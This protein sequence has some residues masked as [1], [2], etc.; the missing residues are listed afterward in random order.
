MQNNL[1][2]PVVFLLLS[3]KGDN[4]LLWS[5]GD[6]VETVKHQTSCNILL[7]RIVPSHQ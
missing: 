5:A 2:H 3:G 1:C 6:N 7:L 4:S